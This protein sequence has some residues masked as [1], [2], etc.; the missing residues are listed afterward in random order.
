MCVLQLHP[1]PLK[2]NEYVTKHYLTKSNF[3]LGVECKQKLKYYKAK[4][5]SSLQDNDML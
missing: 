4:Y 2:E 3:K 1:T 5:P